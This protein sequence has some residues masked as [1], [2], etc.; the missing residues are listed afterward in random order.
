M[1]TLSP[2]KIVPLLLP[3]AF[4]IILLVLWLPERIELLDNVYMDT[5]K[6]SFVGILL[7]ALPFVLAGALL[8]SL[9]QVFVPDEVLPR[10]AWR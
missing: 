8:S 7:E 3:A 4:L 6:T 5:F 2:F 10:A 1:T 9:L